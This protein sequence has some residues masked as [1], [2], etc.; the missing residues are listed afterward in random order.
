MPPRAGPRPMEIE[1]V[2]ESTPTLASGQPAARATHHLAPLA[3][4]AEH[5]H[6]KDGVAGSIPA[7]GS[8]PNQQLR[9]GPA[10]GLSHA[11]SASNHHLPEI[12]QKTLF[13]VVRALHVA[14]WRTGFHDLLSGADDN[15][16]SSLNRRDHLGAISGVLWRR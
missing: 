13:V 2:L 1:E 3:Q 5:I 10:P 16:Q 8:T 14:Q 11:R 4:S 7:G 6:G 15:R 12:C 9:P